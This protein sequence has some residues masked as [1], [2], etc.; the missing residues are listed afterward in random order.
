VTDEGVYAVLRSGEPLFI[1][2]LADEVLAAG[3][4]D[5]EH[6]ALLRQ[7]GMRSVLLTPMAAR[8]R[9]LAVLTLVTADSAR[10]FGPADLEFAMAV[11]RRAGLAID[12]A[13]RFAER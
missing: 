7:V 13:Q 3:V 12:T 9:T 1:P 4:P 8:G 2:E 10:A 11:S 5:P 6:L